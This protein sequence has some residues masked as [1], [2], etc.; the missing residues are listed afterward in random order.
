MNMFTKKSQTGFS[1]LE[2][3][4]AMALGLIVVTGVVQLFIGNSRSAA[5]I[6]G[7]A[8]L[9][10]NARF[11]FEFI[12]RAARQ[13]GYFGCIRDDQTR[14]WGLVGSPAQLPEYN[15]EQPV[16]G[17]N[18]NGDGTWTPSA[19][20]LPG[21]TPGN[22]NSGGV[23]TP[24]TLNP[25]SD[26]IVFRSLRRPIQRLAQ[27]LQPGDDAV[28]TAPGGDPGFDT[29]DIVMITDCEQSVIYRI[30]NRTIAGSEATLANAP[31]TGGTSAFFQNAA[32]VTPPAGPMVNFT[33]SFLGRS[34]GTDA[35]VGAIESTYFF[36]AD[37]TRNNN[38]GNTPLALW[39]KV[40]PTAPV[41][42]IQGVEDLQ[43]LYGIDTT[44][45]DDQS[46]PN[47][48]V[49]A[50]AIPDP[51]QVVA[52]NVRLTVNSIDQVT[53][54]NDVLRRTFSKTILIRNANPQI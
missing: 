8:R 46:N 34:Y 27:T 40:G 45:T 5:V 11:A 12:S 41:E 38:A 14:V 35:T 39:Q 4:L 15:V 43:I 16:G 17:F 20:N 18:A 25:N 6:T 9:Q 13:A 23:I 31:N 3:L 33:K 24:A 51:H 28:V 21:G 26:I 30:T 1:L 37:S 48:Y 36:I 54:A 10:E 2:M 49:L 53:D 32:L 47:R 44:L 7:Q 42:L 29:N 19:V 22:T 52:I 50:P